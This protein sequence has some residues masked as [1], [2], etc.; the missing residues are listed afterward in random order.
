ML[1]SAP[2]AGLKLLISKDINERT[3]RSLSNH[4]MVECY[5]YLEYYEKWRQAQK[6]DRRYVK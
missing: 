5:T 3:D 6:T 2:P 4:H 1:Q